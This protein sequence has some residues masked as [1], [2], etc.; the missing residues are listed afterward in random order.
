M[1]DL[2]QNLLAHDYI[3]IPSSLLG[4]AAYDGF[5]GP[6]LKGMVIVFV[7]VNGAEEIDLFGID[8][9]AFGDAGS[10]TQVVL[11]GNGK[12][13]TITRAGVVK[14]FL[15]S[16]YALLWFNVGQGALIDPVRAAHFRR[17]LDINNFDHL[18]H[19]YRLG[20]VLPQTP[21]LLA[22]A[23]DPTQDPETRANAQ[24]ALFQGLALR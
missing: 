21:A 2:I 6:N 14:L 4:G 17:A 18:V 1:A 12:A 7:G 20:D 8:A 10:L 24:L 5:K 11:D 16:T 13:S 9:V 3:E 22:I 15:P 19:L 23:N